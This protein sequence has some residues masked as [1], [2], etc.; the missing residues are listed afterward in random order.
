MAKADDVNQLARSALF[1]QKTI[2]NVQLGPTISVLDARQKLRS[3]IARLQEL[4]DSMHES[5][6]FALLA[7]NSSGTNFDE[8][9][10]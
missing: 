7:P 1:A 4:S 10:F 3:V 9:G 6:K 8:G 5:N 2:T